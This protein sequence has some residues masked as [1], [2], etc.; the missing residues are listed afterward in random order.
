[1]LGEELAE[2]R[3]VVDHEDDLAIALH[4]GRPALR[5]RLHHQLT[6]GARERARRGLHHGGSSHVARDINTDI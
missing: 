2:V 1:M 5:R 6:P 4:P 3:V